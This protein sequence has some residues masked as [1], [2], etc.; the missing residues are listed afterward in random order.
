MDPSTPLPSAR[1]EREE[2]IA[3]LEA[4]ISR[5]RGPGVKLPVALFAIAACVALLWMQRLDVG[6][7]FS[8]KEPLSLGAEGDY[9]FDQLASNRYAQVHGVPTLRGA[10]SV[11][12]GT[13][14]VVVGLRDTPLLV[15]RQAFPSEEWKVG[16]LPPQPVQ[17]PFA[18]R[19]RLL[20]RQDAVRYEEG[21]RQLEPLGEVRPRNGQLWILI[22]GERPGEN[23]VT[24]L[25]ILGLSAFAVVHAWFALRAVRR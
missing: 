10:Y 8:P 6:Y 25:W 2:R 20:S 24:L 9:H 7:H 14:Y 19:G 5:R 13:T 15:R 12:E 17:S 22:E 18:V 3:E 4:R 16:T 21:F 1:D 11:E 23:P